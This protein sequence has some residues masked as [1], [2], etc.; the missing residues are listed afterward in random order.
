MQKTLELI[1]TA[2]FFAQAAQTKD[3]LE[4]ADGEIIYNMAG[5]SK[6]HEQIVSRILSA[7][8]KIL[9]TTQQEI[10]SSN[11]F[12]YIRA[13]NKFVLPDVM[14]VEG[15]EQIYTDE[16]EGFKPL[17]NPKIIVE[18]TSASTKDY[19]HNEKL[20]CYQQIESV[21]QIILVSS[22]KTMVESYTYQ[23]PNEWHYVRLRERNQSLDVAGNRISI[24]EIYR[25]VVFS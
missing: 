12:L 20:E 3:R 22:Q 19:D 10:Y 24:E 11:R 9:D 13:C 16:R 5:A 6:E 25:K 8:F 18:V 1:T 7:L 23:S 14:V 17:L 21:K 4:Y 2:D 15:E